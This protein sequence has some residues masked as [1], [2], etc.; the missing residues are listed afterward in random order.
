MGL[1]AASLSA[2]QCYCRPRSASCLPLCLA[3]TYTSCTG[4]W[5]SKPGHRQPW[6]QLQYPMGRVC[7]SSVQGVRL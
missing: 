5:Q 2:P 1:Q 6:N 3:I 4:F 7:G